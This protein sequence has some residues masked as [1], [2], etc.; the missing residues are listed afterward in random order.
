MSAPPFRAVSVIVSPAT[1]PR[2]TAAASSKSVSSVPAVAASPVVVSSRPA[3]SVMVP[4]VAMTPEALKLPEKSALEVSRTMDVPNGI[5][6][7]PTEPIGVTT[8]STACH[9]C[10]L[11]PVAGSTSVPSTATPNE[12]SR[13]NPMLWPSLRMKKP[14]P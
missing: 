7:S 10:T 12:P 4:V 14:F 2:L 11:R 3:P 1:S 6:M 9:P 8:P 5:T 13:V